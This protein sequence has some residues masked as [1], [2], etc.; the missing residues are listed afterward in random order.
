MGDKRG[1]VA[2]GSGDD[3][4]QAVAGRFGYFELRNLVSGRTSKSY[5]SKIRLT[6]MTAKVV[7]HHWVRETITSRPL[8]EDSSVVNDLVFCH[9]GS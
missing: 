8:R 2:L 9:D 4:E 1:A 5:M 6:Q 3:Y 7:I